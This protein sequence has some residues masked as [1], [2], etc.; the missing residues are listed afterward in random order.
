LSWL[1]PSSSKGNSSRPKSR[2]QAAGKLKSSPFIWDTLN[3]NLTS[4]QYSQDLTYLTSRKTMK[5]FIIS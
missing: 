1:R 3:V 5:T 2:G 4:I